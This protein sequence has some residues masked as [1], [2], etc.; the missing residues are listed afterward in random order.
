VG[1]Y[2]T[3]DDL[4]EYMSQIF[5]LAFQTEGL[6]AKLNATGTQLKLNLDDPDSTIAIDFGK[7][8]VQ[9]GSDITIDVD[10]D[11]F[12]SADVA[13]KFWLGKVNVPLAMA[14]KQIKVKGSVQ[15]VLKL[16]PL[17]SPLHSQY[18]QILRDAGRTDLLEG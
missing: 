3:A 14:K 18:E 17:M 10:V 16:A 9:C 12:M 8:I 13:H 15:K 11:L 7:G 4:Y 1:V 2:K 6:G 5:A